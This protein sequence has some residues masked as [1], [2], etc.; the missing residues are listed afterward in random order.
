MFLFIIKYQQSGR[1]ILGYARDCTGST[2]PEQTN[3]SDNCHQ[4]AVNCNPTVKPRA[5]M[6]FNLV[7][8]AL[9]PQGLR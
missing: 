2:G 7:K 6:C 8:Y 3:D 4:L 1:L 9:F 5:A